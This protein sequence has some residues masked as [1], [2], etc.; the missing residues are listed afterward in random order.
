MLVVRSSF[1]GAV[2]WQQGFVTLFHQHVEQKDMRISTRK[3]DDG[4]LYK[5]DSNEEIL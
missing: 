2:T 1:P 4:L 3:L 5:C